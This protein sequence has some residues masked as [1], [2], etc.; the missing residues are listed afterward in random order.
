MDEQPSLEAQLHGANAECSE[1]HADRAVLKE[2]LSHIGGWYYALTGRMSKEAI[3]RVE[4]IMLEKDPS[5][6]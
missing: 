5:G 3:E 6:P 4:S 2:A 1:L